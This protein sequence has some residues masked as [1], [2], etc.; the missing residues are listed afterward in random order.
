MKKNTPILCC[1]D[2][3]ES[4]FG[5]FKMK[6]TQSMSGIYASVLCIPLF[7]NNLT[8]ELITDILTKTKFTDVEKWFS[9]MTGKSDLSKRR[10]AF[11]TKNKKMEKIN[12]AGI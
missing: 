5:K 7:C 11:P 9:E 4:I 6:A 3:I 2:I 8:D 12:V 1:S 10:T